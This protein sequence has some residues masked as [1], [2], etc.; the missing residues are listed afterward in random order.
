MANTAYDVAL[1]G[2][3][4]S[5]NLSKTKSDAKSM[6]N[7]IAGLNTA[8][9]NDYINAMKNS[10]DGSIKY[11]EDATNQGIAA[12]DQQYQGVYDKNEIQ[13]II[14][15]R[16]TAD[17]L[18]R[19]GLGKSGLN[20]TQQAAFAVQQNNA[21]SAATQQK[22]GAANNLRSLLQQ[23]KVNLEQTRLQNEAQARYDTANRNSDTYANLYNNAMNLAGNFAQSD[24][25]GIN[26][27][28][29]QKATQDHD[30]SE[31]QKDRDTTARENQ[32]NRDATALENQKNRDFQKKNSVTSS[33]SSSSRS[34][35]YSSVF[36]KYGE[37]M[38]GGST[39]AE[40]NKY[41]NRQVNGGMIT[42]AEAQ[43]IVS[44]YLDDDTNNSN[45]GNLGNRRVGSLAS[46]SYWK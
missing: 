34:S 22:T 27:S 33:G 36:D 39:E 8:A 2:D 12:L 9:V 43:Q 35:K 30:T 15:Q 44:A 41:L 7:E 14:G 40:L 19:M 46:H 6:G 26:S 23:Y 11:M 31:K 3:Y 42:A 16:Q 38:D 21:D 25:S 18:S 20:A 24:A 28:R 29:S 1:A 17:T 4:Y 13:R 32:K 37:M 10:Y 45:S 5:K